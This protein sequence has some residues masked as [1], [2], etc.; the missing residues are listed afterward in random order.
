[1]R[2][3]YLIKWVSADNTSLALHA[4]PGIGLNYCYQLYVHVQ[5][6]RVTCNINRSKRDKL[7]YS[8]HICQ[9]WVAEADRIEN[10]W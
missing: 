2:V 10:T 7:V 5:T 3:Y 1:M 6:R 8:G 4:L 9:Q